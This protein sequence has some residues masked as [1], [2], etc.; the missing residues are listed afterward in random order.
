MKLEELIERQKTM[1]LVQ[2]SAALQEDEVPEENF[3]V[4]PSNMSQQQQQQQ[5]LHFHSLR[6]AEES[7]AHMINHANIL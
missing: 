1:S 3:I 7:L 4:Q 6:K 5:Q 2:P